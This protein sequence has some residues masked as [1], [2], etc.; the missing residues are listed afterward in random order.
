MRQLRVTVCLVSCAL[1]GGAAPFLGCGSDS[2]GGGATDDAAGDVTNDVVAA[3]TS[4][5]DS[6]AVDASDA[7]VPEPLFDC[8]TDS[9]VDAPTH[10]RCTGL[11]DR[12][13]KKTIL[14]TVQEYKPAVTFWSD[15]AEK[16]R[17]IFL[18]P[19]TQIDTTD[20][21][22]WVFPVGTKLWKEFAF[23]GKRVETRFFWKVGSTTWVRTTYQW[24]ADEQSAVR[25]DT[26]FSQ[27]D[28]GDPDA[29]AYE[30]PAVAKCDTCHAGSTDKILG[31][32]GVALALPGAT[33]YSLPKLVA[34]GK[35]TTNP[36]T[37]ALTIPDDGLGSR[38]ALGWLHANCGIACH[39]TTPNAA[40]EFKGMHL[41]LTYA[42]LA[43]ATP[44]ASLGPYAT[45]V[46]VGATIPAAG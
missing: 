19:G 11:Y 20:M 13:T 27:N 8:S 44:L 28:A 40:C 2:S 21:E 33:G 42:E 34:D 14:A 45:T 46:K 9:A 12:W 39:N 24:S 7:D 29:G 22:Q 35:L 38:N 6:P 4:L 30:I 31:F 3:D 18:P 5:I 17:W 10:L 41:R 37:T 26:G 23:G 1:I 36:A 16:K 25:L 43:A 32:A 15:G